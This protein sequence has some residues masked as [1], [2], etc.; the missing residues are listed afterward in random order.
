M[1][2]CTCGKKYQLKDDAA[3]KKFKC[4]DCAEVVKIP[5]KQIDDLEDAD[6][7]ED[8]GDDGEMNLPAR[9]QSKESS[10]AV[11]MVQG[12]IWDAA[13]DVT[14]TL[15]WIAGIFMG[16]L[17]AIFLLWAVFFTVLGSIMG[18]VLLSPIGFVIFFAS[19]VWGSFLTV[20]CYL[21]AKASFG[22]GLKISRGNVWRGTGSIVVGMLIVGFVIL[23]IS[24]TAVGMSG[25]MRRVRPGV[26]MPNLAPPEHIRQFRQLVVA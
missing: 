9:K 19:L 3:G 5:D 13:N 16:L 15:V 21:G 4:K 11:V 18:L 2:R 22:L 26:Q 17:G 7:E 25:G 20:A 23:C 6:D 14:V 12:T 8:D 10:Q 24:L 1:V